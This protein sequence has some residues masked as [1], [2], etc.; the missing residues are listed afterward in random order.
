MI[1]VTG[2]TGRIGSELVRLLTAK[3]VPVRVLTR[4]ASKAESLARHGVEI[5]VGNMNDPRGLDAAMNGV[6]QVFLL[7]K[8]EPAQVELQHNVVVAAV[9]AGVRRLVKVSAMG[10]GPDSP[11]REARWHARTEDEIAASGLAYTHLRPNFFMH[12]LTIYAASL[13]D[14]VLSAPMGGSRISMIDHRDVAA[15]AAAVLTEPGHEHRSYTLTGPEALSFAEVADRLSRA[16]GHPIRYVNVSLE[17]ARRKWLALGIPTWRVDS[18]ID[19]HREYRTDWAAPVTTD[20][21]DLVG[22]PARSLAAIAA[23]LLGSR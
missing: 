7:S 6:G 13:G 20:V 22:R 12:N 1:L 5:A 11:L 19:I 15:A 21:A 10:A 16:L 14:G 9:S 4:D 18:F 23:D 17:D 3:A 2:G 8:E